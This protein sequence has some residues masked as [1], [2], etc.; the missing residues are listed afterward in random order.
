MAVTMTSEYFVQISAKRLSVFKNP[1]HVLK[2]KVSHFEHQNPGFE[3][4]RERGNITVDRFIFTCI[5]VE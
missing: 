2:V 5:S 4:Y 1:I 3:W